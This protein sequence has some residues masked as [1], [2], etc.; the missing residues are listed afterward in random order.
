[1]QIQR[2]HQLGL[3]GRVSYEDPFQPATLCIDTF[4]FRWDTNTHPF[5]SRCT[6][7][8]YC[9]DDNSQCKERIAPG[10]RCELVGKR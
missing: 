2:M 5:P 9:P 8:T 4:S 10:G 1:M 7:N 3:S 6:G